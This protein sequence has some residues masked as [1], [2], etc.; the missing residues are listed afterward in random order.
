ML[1][2]Y[3]LVAVVAIKNGRYAYG[4]MRVLR[5]VFQSDRKPR[6][7]T[8]II[9]CLLSVKSLAHKHDSSFKAST[10]VGTEYYRC[11]SIWKVMAWIVIMLIFLL[12]RFFNMFGDVFSLQVSFEDFSLSLF[13]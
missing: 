4:S 12:Y 2:L 3:F 10:A 9:A 11:R 7:S 13:P 5:S 6:D 8:L 1:L